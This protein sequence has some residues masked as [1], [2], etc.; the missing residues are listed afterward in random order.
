MTTWCSYAVQNVTVNI[1]V[2]CFAI[3]LE[4]EIHVIHIIADYNSLNNECKNLTSVG[5]CF[6]LNYSYYINLNTKH[7]CLRHKKP[8]L[9]G[10]FN[11]DSI[12][13][14]YI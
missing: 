7:F 13:N 11:T 10:L 12:Q 2:N 5:T 4:S 8:H 14:L 3:Q 9:F 1:N 6:S